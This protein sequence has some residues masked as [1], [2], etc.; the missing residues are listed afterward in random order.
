MFSRDS[1]DPAA[2][3]DRFGVHFL[4]SGSSGNCTLVRDGKD[5]Y[6][7][8]FGLKPE[9]LVEMLK[10]RGVE[11]VLRPQRCRPKPKAAQPASAGPQEPP[12]RLTA[13]ILT[14]LHGDHFSATTLRILHDNNVRLWVHSSHVPELEEHR[15]FRNM[16][17]KGLVG[18]YNGTEF[19]VA[20]HTRV[21]PLKLPHDSVPTCGF[22]FERAAHTGRAKF[23]YLA[24]LGH[25]PHDLAEQVQD[26]DLLAIEFNHDVAM[27]RESGRHPRHIARVL[28]SHGHLSN[29]QAADALRMVLARSARVK[30]RCIALLHISRDC[31]TPQL[32][33]DA[34]SRVLNDHHP[35]AEIIVT[36]HREY[37]G[38]VEL[39]PQTP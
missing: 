3:A 27:E 30:P 21:T 6:L 4:A 5:N 23:S 24:D 28:G 36:R 20:S 32:A 38:G 11:L 17:D 35:E 10:A 14:H 13:A 16:A 29:D 31:N 39:L 2:E 19:Q 8:D 34:A 18:C 33:L 26:S 12:T 15:Q 25:F 7:L 9:A 22:V 37:A 1:C